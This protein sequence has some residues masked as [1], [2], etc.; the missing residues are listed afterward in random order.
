VGKALGA[1]GLAEMGDGL[2]VAEEILEAHGL[3]VVNE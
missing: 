3:S 1:D 2:G